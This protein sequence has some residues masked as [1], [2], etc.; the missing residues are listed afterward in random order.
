MAA[1][2]A[3]CHETPGCTESI[4]VDLF[5]CCTRSPFAFLPLFPLFFRPLLPPPPL[6]LSLLPL[7]PFCSILFVRLSPP[8]APLLRFFFA[9]PPSFPLFLSPRSVCTP[10]PSRYHAY[11]ATMRNLLSSTRT[12]HTSVV[13]V[14]RRSRRLPYP[15]RRRPRCC[16]CHPTSN[17]R[18]GSSRGNARS[19]Y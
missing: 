1:R 15:P 11:A 13:V 14:A 4:I 12:I 18:R 17:R 16:S 3:L 6:S 2:C 9:N 7:S 19:A 5:I 8:F 10:R